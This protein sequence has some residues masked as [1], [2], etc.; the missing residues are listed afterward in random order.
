MN[1]REAYPSEGRIEEVDLDERDMAL[2]GQRLGM[3]SETI[4]FCDSKEQS[5][6]PHD[7]EYQAPLTRA[8]ANNALARSFC[9]T[10]FG[11]NN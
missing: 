6:F 1:S 10:G 11:T 3:I 4:L 8:D 7:N 9:Y 2:F 5:H